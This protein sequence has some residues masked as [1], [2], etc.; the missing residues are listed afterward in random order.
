[1]SSIPSGWA[2]NIG[3]SFLG[4][5][6]PFGLAIGFVLGGVFDWRLG[7]YITSGYTLLLFMI[8]IWHLPEDPQMEIVTWQKLRIKVDWVG[9]IIS[10]TSLGLLSYIFAY[11]NSLSQALHG[12]SLHPWIKLIFGFG[13][14]QK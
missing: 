7:F 13:K 10:S 4:L 5:A 2:R 11:V 3:F 14:R 8:N 12:V 6:V 9:A 1:M